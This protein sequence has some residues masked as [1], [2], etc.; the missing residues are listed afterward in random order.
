MKRITRT[1]YTRKC[2]ICSAQFSTTAP[3]KICCSEKCQHL[4][5]SNKVILHRICRECASSCETTHINK[6][7][8]SSR[9][10]RKQVKIKDNNRKPTKKYSAILSTGNLGAVGELQASVDLMLRGFHVFGALSPA[11]PCDLIVAMEDVVIK[12]EV[13]TASYQR[14]DG[15]LSYSYDGKDYANL[16]AVIYDGKVYYYESNK[17]SNEIRDLLIKLQMLDVK[18]TETGDPSTK[19]DM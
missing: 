8:C 12:V 4:R 18:P 11:S 3:K 17:T 13:R 2:P 7:L 19:S 6:L 14:Q 10:Y 16:F 5:Y 9:C 15:T 1:K